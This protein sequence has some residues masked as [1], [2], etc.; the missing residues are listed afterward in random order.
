MVRVTN[1]AVRAS[2]SPSR[3]VT[4]RLGT[5]RRNRRA[6]R[7]HSG[8]RAR[9]RAR[10][11]SCRA[12][13]AC[14]PSSEASSTRWP[15]SLQSPCAI[16]GIFA[17]AS[18][19]LSRTA[20]GADGVNR[21]RCAMSRALGDV[22]RKHQPTGPLLDVGRLLGTY[23]NAKLIV[24]ELAERGTA[25]GHVPSVRHCPRRLCTPTRRIR[26]SC[27]TS[28]AAGSPAIVAT[29]PAGDARRP[30]RRRR[31]ARE[32]ERSR[33]SPRRRSDRAWESARRI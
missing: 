24:V 5:R 25:I 15:R 26:C 29:S 19:P 17:S 10:V 31:T 32:P 11:H 27:R 3:S 9:R 7:V 28:T 22:P 21:S 33:E 14:R 13:M 20:P 4:T 12:S 2:V 30:S 8:E 16:A 1:P 6:G 23:E 18:G